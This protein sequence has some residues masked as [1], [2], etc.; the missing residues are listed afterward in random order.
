MMHSDCSPLPVLLLSSL[1][2]NICEVATCSSGLA[3]FRG[4]LT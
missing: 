2:D 4:L 1:V 3:Y